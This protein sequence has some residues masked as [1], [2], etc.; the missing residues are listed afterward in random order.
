MKQ[1]LTAMNNPKINEQLQKEKNI[2]VIGK[3]IPY[4]EGILEILEKNK[5][6]NYILI[7]ENIEGEKK[8]KNLLKKI[9]NINNKI[10]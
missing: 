9:K 10:K 8:K 2:K 6:I 7:S 3:D 4:K 1:I 5:Y